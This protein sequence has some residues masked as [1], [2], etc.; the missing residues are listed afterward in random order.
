MKHKGYRKI[1]NICQSIVSNKEN[2]FDIIILKFKVTVA[3]R[4]ILVASITLEGISLGL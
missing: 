1:H 4:V 3:L 2:N